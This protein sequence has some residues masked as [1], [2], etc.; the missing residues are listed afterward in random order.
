MTAL[1]FRTIVFIASITAL[2][3]ALFFGLITLRE[4]NRHMLFWTIAFFVKAMAFFLICQR[5]YFPKWI[6]F[7]MANMLILVSLEFLQAGILAL[8]NRSIRWTLMVFLDAAA[9]GIL[10]SAHFFLGYK[11]F[12][13][14]LSLMIAI[15]DTAVLLTLLRKIPDGM[16]HVHWLTA[17]IFGIDILLLLLQIVWF[18]L[19]VNAIAT[20]TGITKLLF[21]NLIFCN[22]L[23]G[24]ALL[25]IIYWRMHLNQI[26]LIEELEFALSQVHTLQGLLPI[27]A[28][29][30]KIRD[31]RGSWQPIEEFVLRRT[32]AE[33]SHG[34]CPECRSKLDDEMRNNYQGMSD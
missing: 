20:P 24:L 12:V 29:C 8:Q 2:S 30:K 9:L 23:L 27:C 32:D 6:S 5:Q 17:S 22:M 18:I 14:A 15:G 13:I 34:I 10:V 21:T 25:A 16:K 4:R 3:M 33:F 1:D 26:V 7:S 31:D 28:W 19:G 11:T